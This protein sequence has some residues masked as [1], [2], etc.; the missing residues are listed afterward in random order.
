MRSPQWYCNRGMVMC[1]HLALKREN[2]IIL[3]LEH[4]L[5]LVAGQLFGAQWTLWICLVEKRNY[6]K[7]GFFSS[8]MSY[9]LLLMHVELFI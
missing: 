7:K 1:L 5:A 3:H 8:S 4:I 6:L 2:E 9:V